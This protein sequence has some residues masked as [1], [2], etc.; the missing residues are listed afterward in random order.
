MKDETGILLGKDQLRGSH[1]EVAS[2]FICGAFG[3]GK[4]EIANQIIKKFC[5][6]VIDNVGSRGLLIV[7]IFSDR[8]YC[9]RIM[10]EYGIMIKEYQSKGIST[11]IGV[12]SW[13]LESYAISEKAI[14]VIV[15]NKLMKRLSI[16]H[17][18]TDILLVLDEVSSPF[19]ED[20]PNWERLNIPPRIKL[21]IILKPTMLPAAPYCFKPPLR[22]VMK[23]V[24]LTRQ[25][26]SSTNINELVKAISFFLSQ[27]KEFT[28]LMPGLEKCL[29]GHEVPGAVT[30]WYSLKGDFRGN[31]Q[32]LALKG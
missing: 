5:N 10:E 9:S 31:L 13:F 1:G 21:V 26:R 11:M 27:L 4:T 14:L 16:V 20:S 25:Y 32:K 24:L 15:I 28:I 18:N 3:A 22:S 29:T 23:F 8:G 6:H 30:E 19:G 17:S 12:K 2:T 7:S